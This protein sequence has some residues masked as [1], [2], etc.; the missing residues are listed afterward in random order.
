MEQIIIIFIKRNV[1]CHISN[2]LEIFQYYR[3]AM[4][5]PN[6]NLWQRWLI[7]SLR[8]IEIGFIIYFDPCCS[9]NEQDVMFWKK[10]YRWR[11]INIRYL[12]ATICVHHVNV[13]RTRASSSTLQFNMNG[14]WI[15]FWCI[16][17][18]LKFVSLV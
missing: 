8:K 6:G 1:T 12:F 2:R 11:K 10:I 16:H 5:I 3:K 14:F 9:F 18:I 4:S 13:K 7:H 15:S 17:V